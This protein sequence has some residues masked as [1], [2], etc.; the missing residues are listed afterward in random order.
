MS[1]PSLT[2][3]QKY[4][5]VLIAVAS[6][7]SAVVAEE[8]VSAERAKTDFQTRYAAALDAIARDDWAGAQVFLE[9]AL[10]K[11]GAHE[12]P[13]K[14]KAQ[15]I[16][17]KA[18]RTNDR[19]R[20][21][22]ST[23]K[24]AQEL[25]RQK[26]WADAIVMFK[27]AKELGVD[28]A[29]VAKGIQEAEA[30]SGAAGYK[31][32]LADGMAALGLEDWAGAERAFVKALEAQPDD[33][34]ASKGL[35]EAR[36]HLA[37]KDVTPDSTKTTP[38]AADAAAKKT[39]PADTPATPASTEPV[40]VARKPLPLPQPERLVRDQWEKGS[41]S[42]CYWAGAL[43]HLEEGDEKFRLPLTGDFAVQIAVEARMDHRSKIYLD[44]RPDKKKAFPVARG[45]GSYEGSAPH[46][47]VGKDVCGRGSARPARERI[48]LGFRR[49]G[50]H[51]EFF[52]DGKKIG[53]TFAIPAHAA[54]WLYVCGKGYM[55]AG[56]V[57]RR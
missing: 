33:S 52:C 7:M 2:S 24:T 31:K 23:L 21:M 55:Y 16:L 19:E 18:K 22:K 57:V 17:V 44:L 43:L 56:K 35:K 49:T 46:L 38:S 13:D 36:A 42:T 30:G 28:P 25:L 40:V 11:L 8:T 4:L 53:E 50:A 45:Y 26:Q 3:F 34:A 14:A 10:K 27:K 5:Y 54:L 20:E 12:H 41:G 15:A 47:K 1:M 9:S 51:I 29:L 32:H 48:V 6:I 37:K 39:P